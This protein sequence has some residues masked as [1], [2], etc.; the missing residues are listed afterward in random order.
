MGCCSL[1]NTVLTLLSKTV[2]TL[3]YE[4]P[5]AFLRE[6]PS[7]PEEAQSCLLKLEKSLMLTGNS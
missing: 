7:I 1:Y 6:V 2:L 4:L 3:F 5:K